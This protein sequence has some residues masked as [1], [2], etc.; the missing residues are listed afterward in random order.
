MTKGAP[1]VPAVLSW[2]G[3][4]FCPSRRLFLARE[5]AALLFGGGMPLIFSP[6][7][8]PKAVPNFFL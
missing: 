6:S 7:L 5:S 1:L 8:F 2:G 4:F 3:R